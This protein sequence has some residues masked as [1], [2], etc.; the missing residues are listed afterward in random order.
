MRARTVFRAFLA[1]F[2]VAA[3]QV[4][5]V[6]VYSSKAGAPSASSLEAS[7]SVS[8]AVFAERA[9]TSRPPAVYFI[10]EYRAARGTMLGLPTLAPVASRP[11]GGGLGASTFSV[12]RAEADEP[13]DPAATAPQATT[14]GEVVTGFDRKELEE[15]RLLREPTALDFPLLHPD[16]SPPSCLRLSVV[17]DGRTAEWERNPILSLGYG[18]RVAIPFD[19]IYNVDAIPQ[20]ML[21]VGPWLGPVRLRAELGIGGAAATARNPNLVGYSYSGGVAA[22]VLLLDVRRFGLGFEAAYDVTSINFGSN[23]KAY[24]QEGTGYRGLIHGPRAGLTFSLLPEPPVSPAFAAR[25]N[26]A[27]GSIELYVAPEWSSE[28]AS[29]TPAFFLVFAADGGL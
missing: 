18:F 8:H 25:P 12:A 5:C 3:V 7:V 27:S 20:F 14:T 6:S 23:V 26:S 9:S 22:D 2:A 21:R 17:R 1:S 16:G 24:S 28:R 11:C 29:A 13:L 10:G 4:G 19:R 15:G